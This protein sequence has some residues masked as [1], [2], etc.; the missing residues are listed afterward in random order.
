MGLEANRYSI[1]GA[2]FGPALAGEY[3]FSSLAAG[4]SLGFFHDFNDYMTLEPGA[5]LRWF[6]FLGSRALM[7]G[8]Y[9]EGRVGAG[10]VN[11]S[12]GSVGSPSG[13]T[14]SSGSTAYWD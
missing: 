11:G 1:N 14:N 4:A 9:I 13:G 5:F 10:T 6:P 2:A 12:H 8:L 3:R 7:Q